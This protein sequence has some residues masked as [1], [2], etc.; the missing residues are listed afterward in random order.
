MNL[1]LLHS[2]TLLLTEAP[3]KIS[4][5]ILL[6]LLSLTL[7]IASAC[8][9]E[10]VSSSEDDQRISPA[11]PAGA[12]DNDVAAT[13]TTEIGDERSPNEGGVLTDNAPAS[14]ERESG[15]SVTTTDPNN[16]RPPSAPVPTATTT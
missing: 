2:Q 11:T 16:T 15:S 10:K 5:A 9:G 7:T 13:Q 4:K 12:T 8:R 3:L 6:I 14:T 1:R